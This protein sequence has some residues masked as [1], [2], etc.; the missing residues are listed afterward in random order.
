[1]E[2]VRKLENGC[3]EWQAYKLPRGYGLFSFCGQDALA[4]RVAYELFVGP[5]GENKDV[6]HSCD[7]PSCV[8]PD[9]LSL[10]SRKDNMQDAKKKGRMRQGE[11][12]GRS[13]LTDAQAKEIKEASGFQ[14]EIAE[15]YGV[16]QTTVWEIKSGRKRQHLSQ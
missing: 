13:V 6:M 2:K 14:R 11:T 15:K 10:G 16:S 4:H 7:N 1:M 12:H 5:L 8:N 9:H 3:W